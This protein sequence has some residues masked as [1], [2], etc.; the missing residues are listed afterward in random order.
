[1]YFGILFAPSP[2]IGSLKAAS[3]LLENHTAANST[4]LLHTK[5][6]QHSVDLPTEN[7]TTTESLLF[8]LEQFFK[9]VI[10]RQKH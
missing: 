1:M 8:K 9:L 10:V 6:F 4:L 5:K 3:M 2:G 7:R